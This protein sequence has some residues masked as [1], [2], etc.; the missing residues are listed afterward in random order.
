MKKLLAILPLLG[1]VGLL[2]VLGYYNFHKTTRFAPSEMVGQ[3]VPD[4]PLPN[5]R[6]GAMA[7]L[8]TLA[9]G[10]GKPVIVN[11]YASWCTPCLAEL[12]QL[13]DMKTKNI[14]IIGLAYKDKPVDSLNF[15]NKHS[16]PYAELL[17]DED[18]RFGLKLGISGVPETFV[19]A[20]D[21]KITAKV[22][23]PITQ[24]NIDS[25]LSKL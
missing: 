21:G 24:E 15:L 19:V 11:I 25:L 1:F 12:P 18:G 20:P 7:D 2:S 5:L 13:M 14:I 10:Y 16:D 17:S 6:T 3:S 22:T 23:G 4:D 9:A 8:K